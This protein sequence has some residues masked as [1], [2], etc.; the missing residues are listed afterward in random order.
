LEDLGGA[1]GTGSASEKLV[2]IVPRLG[3]P[4]RV[5]FGTG[6]FPAS[7]FKP[8]TEICGFLVVNRF[9]AAVA[10]LM[11]GCPVEVRAIAARVQIGAALLA[12]LAAPRGA[13]QTVDFSAF[14]TVAGHR[15]RMPK[16]SLGLKIGLGWRIGFLGN[17]QAARLGHGLS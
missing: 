10:T 2:E 8:F 15:G 11:G 12:R 14:P 13:F 7:E 1:K 17:Q 3:S 6:E 4:I 5:A 9:G 16:V